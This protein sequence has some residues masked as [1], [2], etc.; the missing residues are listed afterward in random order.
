[1]RTSPPALAPGLD[2]VTSP[3]SVHV[4]R[5][6]SEAGRAYI[7]VAA[8]I[9]ESQKIVG[10]ILRQGRIAANPQT[11]N[12]IRDL[13]GDSTSGYYRNVDGTVWTTFSGEPAFPSRQRLAAAW[14][15]QAS[16][17]VIQGESQV[18]GNA[19]RARDGSARARRS[20]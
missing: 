7:W 15:D 16:V 5:L 9:T 4:G 1:V 20:R 12:T 10:Y 17:P 14:S 19:A 3:D 8:P 13:S 2:S 11:A 18:R 6:Y